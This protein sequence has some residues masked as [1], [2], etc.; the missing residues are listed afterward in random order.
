LLTEINLSFGQR[1]YDLEKILG[2]K[3]LLL[4]LNLSELTNLFR[5]ENFLSVMKDEFSSYLE[6]KLSS[7][8]YLEKPIDL[9]NGKKDQQAFSE[10]LTRFRNHLEDIALLYQDSFRKVDFD[11][12][13]ESYFDFSIPSEMIP[14]GDNIKIESYFDIETEDDLLSVF[15]DEDLK[16][17]TLNRKKWENL[18]AIQLIFDEKNI[19]ANDRRIL[20]HLLE[21][22]RQIKSLELEFHSESIADEE[23]LVLFPI[24]FSNIQN[25]E[26]IDLSFSGSQIS[27]S[28]IV[29]LFEKYIS[30]IPSLKKLTLDF[31]ETKISSRGIKAFIDNTKKFMDSLIK[32]E[33]YLTKTSLTDED[34]IPIFYSMP[35]APYIYLSLE[36]TEITNNAI[37]ILTNNIKEMENLENF[38]LCLA[39]TKVAVE[40]IIHLIQSLKNMKILYLDLSGIEINNEFVVELDEII[41]SK[42]K[43]LKGFYLKFKQGFDQTGQ[44]LLDKLH[45]DYPIPE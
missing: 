12:L 8:R 24:I 6:Q 31:A 15:V 38:Q 7:C 21:N 13:K 17:L 2:Q 40:T 30:Q 35:K 36:S 26:A 29:V 19:S 14:S 11:S 34:I 44:D 20:L 33:L 32:F 37:E 5:N 16:K 4:D 42:M 3:I 43:S 41:R 45:N 28:N 39:E 1:I 10:E 27:D 18:D 23:I 25:L 9:E 22:I